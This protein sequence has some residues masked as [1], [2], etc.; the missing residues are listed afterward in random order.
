MST[1]AG[2]TPIVALTGGIA[3]GKTAVSQRMEAL[4]VPIVDTDRIAR[5]VVA[6]GTPGLAAVTRAF[7]S[8][9][10]GPDGT[11][12]RKAL[13]SRVFRDPE[14]R[15]RL[16][17]I[18]HPLI[19]AHARDRIRKLAGAPYCVLVVPLLVESGLFPDADL[20][21]VV[22]VPEALQR[23]RLRQRERV[24]DPAIDRILAA[25]A[26]RA[27]RLAR[28]DRVI[29]NTGSLA[30]LNQQVDRLHEDLLERFRPAS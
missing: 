21:V 5:E 7:G 1:A 20:V 4:G 12:D 9:V 25:Q 17:Q 15:K 11:L 10:L 2:T 19:E 30:D 3:S 28:A 8:D 23:K 18:L 13:G 22:D 16:E 24:D 26:E 27:A 14:S 29:E 6:P